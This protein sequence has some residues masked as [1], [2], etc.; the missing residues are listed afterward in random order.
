MSTLLQT[1]APIFGLMALGYA[2]ARA[3]LIERAGAQGLVVFVF[4]FSIPALLLTSMARLELPSDVS[5]GFLIAFY[6]AS[7]VTWTLGIAVGRLFGRPLREQAIFGM[8]AAFSNLVL[9]GIPVVLTA[10]GPDASLPMLAIIGFHSA[11]FMPLTVLLVQVGGESEAVSLGHRTARLLGDVLRNPIILGISVGLLVNLTGITMWAAPAAILDFLGAAAVPC[12]LFAMG[13]SLAGYP[14]TGDV[15]QALALTALKLLVH[16]FLVWLVAVPVLGLEGLPVTVAVLMA[17][18][19]SAVNVYLFGA[20][21]DAAPRVAARTVL[22][23]TVCS[24]VTI[25]T[26]LL[27]LGAPGATSTG[28]F[29]EPGEGTTAVPS[30]ATERLERV[31]PGG[32][33]GGDDCGEQRDQRQA[34]SRRQVRQR[35]SG[36][37]VDEE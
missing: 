22:L 3:R 2:A 33:R 7:L 10:L 26:L 20:R 18:M 9:M 11:T 17:A 19:P 32:A 15:R 16:P 36:A 13:A 6:A 23:T 14:L 12:A 5:W 37:H 24:M 34:R 35:I 28:F 1:M 4:H 31:Q 27:L 8:G 30:V 29:R 21:Y 25:A